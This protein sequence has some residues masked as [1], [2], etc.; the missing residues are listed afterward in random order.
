[1]RQ[2]NSEEKM[3]ALSRV[4]LKGETPG[5]REKTLMVL[6]ITRIPARNINIP[7]STAT[8]A[9]EENGRQSALLAGAK[10]L[11]LYTPPTY[12]KYNEIHPGK[13]IFS[14]DKQ[15]LPRFFSSSV[16]K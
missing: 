16:W 15:G 1:L 11:M 14:L 6:A 2:K 13:G 10:V 7:A 4:P 12:R 8:A 3:R 9:L 5:S